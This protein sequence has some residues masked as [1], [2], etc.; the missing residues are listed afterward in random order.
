MPRRIKHQKP[1]S[2]SA[3]SSFSG[4]QKVCPSAYLLAHDRERL[5]SS[6]PPEANRPNLGLNLTHRLAAP[7]I[8]PLCNVTIGSKVGG[9]SFISVPGMSGTSNF[10]N[11]ST[12]VKSQ[13]YNCPSFD[14]EITNFESP[15][16]ETSSPLLPLLKE[17][18]PS[19]LRDRP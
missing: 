1:S 18:V 16:Q 11:P 5:T 3:F 15:D 9:L 12:G 4:N 8:P 6:S 2:N 7:S 19:G 14:P 13:M 17:G 10:C